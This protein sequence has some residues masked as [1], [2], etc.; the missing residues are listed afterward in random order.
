MVEVSVTEIR[1]QLKPCVFARRFVVAFSGGLDSLVLLNLLQQLQL[2]VPVIALHINHQLSDKANDWEKH[3]EDTCKSLKVPF[4]SRRVSVRKGERGLEDAAREARYKEFSEFLEPGDW[5]LTGHHLDD[6]AET[7]L[8]RL[9]RGSGPKGLGGMP[10]TR[11]MGKGRIHRPLLDCTR[12]SLEHYAYENQLRWVEDE[13][14]A[15]LLHDRNYIRHE[16]IPPLKHRWGALLHNIERSARLARESEELNRELASIDLFACY[17]RQDRYGLSISLGYL[18]GCSR[19]RQKNIVRFWIENNEIDSP[20]HARL[21]A[22]IDSVVHASDDAT[23]L[24]HWNGVECRRFG[25]RL[26]LIDA[27]QDFDPDLQFEME[28]GQVVEVPA[29]GEIALQHHREY[30]FAVPGN[31]PLQVRFRQ[32]GERCRPSN[33]S[34]SQKLKKLFQE[35]EVPPWVRDRVPLV[36]RGDDLVAVGDF[37]ICAGQ[38]VEDS[39]ES[40]QLFCAY[41]FSLDE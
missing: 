29:V 24:V 13:S 38:E 18:K 40:C 34:K 6:Q 9:V 27:L 17:P 32:G 39:K 26:Y 19:V 37:W 3:C 31:S 2:N 23:P 4:F 35:Y 22:I 1:K 11:K 33:R 12:K 15:D 5:L 36:Y 7:Y 25:Q 10:R 28:P 14:N 20:G 30:G 41:D 21:E 16:V 8:L